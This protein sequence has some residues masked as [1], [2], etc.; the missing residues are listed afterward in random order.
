MNYSFNLVSEADGADNNNKSAYN[1]Q[2]FFWRILTRV[3]NPNENKFLHNV[4]LLS[5]LQVCTKAQNRW[6]AFSMPLLKLDCVLHIRA[7]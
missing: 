5:T 2:T 1:I 4:W 6:Q 7:D 3:S